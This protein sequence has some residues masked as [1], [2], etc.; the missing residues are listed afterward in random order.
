MDRRAA[1]A[2]GRAWQGLPSAQEA[3]PAGAV[4]LDCRLEEAGSA[5]PPLGPGLT[6][7]LQHPVCNP[8]GM[9]SGSFF[10]PQALTLAGG[11]G[12]GC[13]AGGWVWASSCDHRGAAVPCGG[14]VGDDSHIL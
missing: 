1:L 12:A 14:L 2:V 3:L 13:S 4:S 9:G 6:E 5:G 10:L 11:T 7:G 8:P